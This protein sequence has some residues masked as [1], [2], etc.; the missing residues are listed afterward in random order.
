M[1]NTRKRCKVCGKL[2][3]KW[4]SINYGVIHC[5]DGCFSTTGYDNRTID[6]KPKYKTQLNNLKLI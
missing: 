4:Q 3:T 6:G 5:Y 2:T 1:L